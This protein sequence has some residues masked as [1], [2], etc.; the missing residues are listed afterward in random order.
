MKK[1]SPTITIKLKELPNNCTECPIYQMNYYEDDESLFGD[2][3]HHY[4]PYGGSSYGCAV[5]RPKDCPLGTVITL[6]SRDQQ[7]DSDLE[8]TTFK[9]KVK[10]DLF[11]EW[12]DDNDIQHYTPYAYNSLRPDHGQRPWLPGRYPP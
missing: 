3:I 9:Y 6:L 8:K 7:V 5:E 12:F 10:E 11:K 2:G 4:C 1:K